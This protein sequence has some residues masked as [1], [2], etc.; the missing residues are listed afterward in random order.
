[1]CYCILFSIAHELGHL[2]LHMA[3]PDDEKGYILSGSYHKETQNTSICEW[4]AEELAA[5]FLMPE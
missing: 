4:E 3:Y 1:M 5:A 2:F